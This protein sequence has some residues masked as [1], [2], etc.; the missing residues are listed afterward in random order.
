MRNLAW[1]GCAL[2]AA[3]GRDAD[4]GGRKVYDHP[5][6]ILITLDTVRAD[7]LSC[8]G[9]GRETTP[10]LDRLA[11]ESVLFTQAYSQSSFTPPSHASILT[12][13]YPSSHGVMWWNFALPEK[14]ETLAELLREQGRR[15]ACFS[16]LAMASHNGLSQGFD[17]V[18]EMKDVG[19]WELKIDAESTYQIAPGAEIN[20]QVS[21]WFGA[22]AD[23]TVFAWIHY[24]DAHRPFSIFAPERR[25]CDNKV[26]TFGNSTTLDY[27]LDP[28][29]RRK[30]GIGPR[31]AE[32]LK[33]RY[34]SGLFALDAVVGELLDDLRAK[35]VLD[36][37]ILVITADHG[38]AFD[39]FEEEWFTHDPFL[40][41]VV[42]HVPL[43]V[44][45]PDRRHGGSRIDELVELID[46]APTVLD[47]CGSR[48]KPE[49]QG[50][51]LR[52]LIEDGHA[53]RP[54]VAAE[55][56]GQDSDARDP[57]RQFSAEQVGFRRSVRTKAG[58]LVVEAATG[59]ERYYDRTAEAVE[60]TDARERG[61]AE[62]ERLREAMRRLG[63]AIQALDPQAT[64]KAIDDDM[65][66]EIEQNGYTAA[67]KKKK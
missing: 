46:I 40:Y 31:Q 14:V 3:C 2:L 28:E 51:S 8:Y 34:D 11:K 55:R 21:K 59:R 38:E 18:V 6:V 44:R 53:V 39:E 42:T 17:R 13:R 37:S 43:L 64:P 65:Q 12:S 9:Y 25:F 27:Q 63:A 10:H 49:M 41:D 33:D 35:G 7:R 36:R 52:P 24:Y 61:G 58:R 50:V 32:Y 23:A 45:F 67:D 48:P 26:D 29:E 47:Y 15:T 54:F 66:R 19:K 4:D 62:V 16:P 5:S 57:S 22:Q 1:L 60:S 56:K 20:K 30:R